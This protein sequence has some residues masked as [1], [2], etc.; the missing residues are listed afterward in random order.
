MFSVGGMRAAG[1]LPNALVATRG[2][3]QGRP[4]Y[5]TF[6]D[7]PVSGITPELCALLREFNA[8]ASFFCIGENLRKHPEIATAI[9]AD[10]HCVANHSD[11]HPKFSEVTL[12][13]R[14]RELRACQ[15]EIEKLD[16]GAAKIVRCPRGELS[17]DL[18]LRLK[19]GGWRVVH[20]SYDSLDYRQEPAQ[21]IAERLI[22]EP[23]RPGDVVLFHDDHRRSLEALATLLPIWV[24]QGF[25]FRTVRE[26]L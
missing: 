2:R 15:A 22:R 19:L 4:L 26:F 13:E 3:S 8:K 20:W 14:M 7:G 16:A 18:L 11:S 21:K 9:A 10:G 24:E 12:G 23:V 17:I 6:D 25:S 5:L 1:R